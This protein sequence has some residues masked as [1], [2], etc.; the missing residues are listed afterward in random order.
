MNFILNHTTPGLLAKIA[1]G[2]EIAFRAFYE[3]NHEQIYGVALALTKSEIIAEEVV[4]DIFLKIWLKR[5][6]LLKIQSPENYLFILIRNHVY[7]TLKKHIRDKNFVRQLS[8]YFKTDNITPEQQLLLNES[9]DI[10]NT[11]IAHLPPKQ[12]LVYELS[13]KEG[14]KQE[15][16]A[17]KLNLS[18]H[19]VKSH[20]NKA[21][22][23]IRHY[24]KSHQ[25]EIGL[26]L[27]LVKYFFYKD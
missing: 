8:A 3:Q 20:M 7:N 9:R 10:V 14:L 2:D 24:I 5:K 17:T 15:E 11:A 6:R 25:E 16:I 22:H 13:R 4:Q 21:L 23:A 1:E 27:L 26:F 12:R 19:T 18:K